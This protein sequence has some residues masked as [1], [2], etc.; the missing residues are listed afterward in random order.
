MTHVLIF[1]PCGNVFS[2]CVHSQIERVTHERLIDLQMY[3]RA[4][5]KE[6]QRRDKA[7]EEGELFTRR[8]LTRDQRPISSRRSGLSGLSFIAGSSSS[9]CGRLSSL[10]ESGL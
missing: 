8:S 10:I 6:T 5:I 9:V 7:V 4:R 3:W 2:A 1:E